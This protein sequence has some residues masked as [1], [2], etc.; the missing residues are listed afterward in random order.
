MRQTKIWIVCVMGFLFLGILI[1]VYLYQFREYN[2]RE[3]QIVLIPKVQDEENDFWTTLIAGAQLAAEEYGA[4]IQVMSGESEEDYQGQNQLLS[5]I[6]ENPPDILAIAPCSLT[7]STDILEQVVQAGVQVV[8]VD[9]HVDGDVADL[10]VAT[11]NVSAGEKLGEF[12]VS[13]IQDK[14][15]PQIAIIGHVE[16]SS[17]AMDREKGVRKGLGEYEQYVTDMM[18]CGSEYGKAYEI[19]LNLVKNNPQL[20]M[21]VGL[22]EYSSVGAARAIRDLGI[23]DRVTMVGFDSSIAQIQLMEEGVFKGIVIQNP[24]NMGYLAIEQAVLKRNGKSR[25][26]NLDSGSKLI[27]MD[28][29]YTEENQKL[30]FPFVGQQGKGSE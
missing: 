17:T 12:A 11:D 8:L 21:V 13:F 26:E 7:K 15:T 19:T 14:E 18:Y 5:Q 25:K 20:D 1:P 3:Y 24:F 6:L 29:L 22:N 2:S 23:Q 16:G 10:I 4:R 9:S 30:L 27:T 28:N